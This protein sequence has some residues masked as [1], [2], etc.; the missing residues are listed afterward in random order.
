M[1][2]LVSPWEIPGIMRKYHYAGAMSSI[3]MMLASGVFFI[4]FG[5]TVGMSN[6]QW[7]LMA[8]IASWLMPAQLVSAIVAQRTG[9]RKKI[10]FCLAVAERMLRMI[11]ILLAL[12]FWQSGWPGAG[13]VLIVAVCV[14]SLSGTMALPPW[15]SWMA[16]VIPKEHHGAFWGRR[17][18]WI[19]L[20]VISVTIPAALLI[21]V[22]P[23]EHKIN[24]MLA[25]FVFAT[26]IGL[27][28]LF[29]HSSI[30]E[31]KL[32]SSEHHHFFREILKPIRDREFRPWLVFHTCWSF[33][34]YLG[35][36][37]FVQFALEEMGLSGNLLGVTLA[38]TC[39]GFAGGLTGGWSGK[40]VDQFGFKRV[41][42]WGHLT[43]AMLPAVWLTARPENAL[44]WLGAGSLISGVACSAANTA[45]N[46]LVTRVPPPELRTV[47]VA[48]SSSAG[49]LAG[50]CGAI[51]AGVIMYYFG[52]SGVTTPLGVLSG[53]QL[54]FTIS[55]C[56]RL[57]TTVLLIPRI[58]L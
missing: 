14:S 24:A 9:E 6:F 3:W 7:G 5:N 42:F 57:S 34:L 1:Q 43:W 52:N 18:A 51:T 8:G 4:Q 20:S 46:K 29:I 30:P 23:L 15:M 10:W 22:V 53:F 13:V 17:T 49:S 41:L 47:Y 12:W 11:G 21:D 44:Y 32:A 58:K 2:R 25:V 48:L 55:L 50:G 37:L 36:A 56:L 40:L 16:D 45:A 33:G 35:G 19:A 38:I 54:L 39:L 31:P 27:T 26:I 28:D